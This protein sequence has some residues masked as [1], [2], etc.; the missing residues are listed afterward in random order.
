MAHKRVYLIRHAVTAGNEK[1]RYVGCRTDEALSAAGIRET[2]ARKAYYED[3]LGDEKDFP[4]ENGEKQKLHFYASP[5][6][7]AMQT[8][9]I[10]FDDPEIT[11]VP[12]FMEIDFGAFEGKDHAELAGNPLY[13]QWIDSNGTLPFPGGEDRDS[14]VKRSLHGFYEV[15]ADLSVDETAVIVCHGGTL[16]AILSELTGREYF[17]FMVG[18]LEGYRLDLEMGHEGILDVSYSRIGDRDPA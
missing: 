18:N 11:R 8:A 10:L 14:F 5:L 6:K 7:R 3:L 16:M 17:D 1:R 2:L 13:Q 12:D 4:G 15:L 9:E